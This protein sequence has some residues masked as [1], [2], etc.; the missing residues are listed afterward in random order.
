MATAVEREAEVVIVG[1]G[2]V[3]CAAAYYLARRGAKVVVVEKGEIAHEQ[4]SR[5]WGWIHQQ[6]RYP[7]LI[8]LA[9]MSA[10][11]WDG[12][13]E[14][15]GADLEWVRGGNLTLGFD[16]DQMAEFE[17]WR[18]PAREAGLETRMLTRDGVSE[19]L[20][21]MAGPW[22]G[23]IHVPSDGQASPQLAT[24]AFARAAQAHGATIHERCSVEAIELHDGAVSGVATERGSIRSG[25]VVVAAGAWSARLC[26]PLGIRLPQRAVRLTVVRTTPTEPVTDVTAWGDRV[27]FRQDRQ[28]RFILAGGG[29]ADYDLNL[30]ALR[31]LRQFV[32][33]AW[34]NRRFLRLRVGRPLLRDLQTLVP[35]T[36]AR[37]QPFAHLRDHEP[38][39]NGKSAQLSLELFKKLFPSLQQLEIERAW[40]GNIDTTPDQGPVLGE[41]GDLPGLTFAT[42]F[43]G[44]GFAMGPG[45]GR[46]VSELILDEGTSLDLH[47]Y[48]Y[49]R[50]AEHD[51]SPLPAL[52]L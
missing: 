16:D 1:A 19:L 50:F 21:T 33:N 47:K 30:D 48:R 44:H 22:I 46:I 15:L 37:R 42:G 9:A 27:T 6:T 10:R 2:I 17:Q 7:H 28:G 4:S 52:R 25:R 35:G 3:G 32:P 18:G 24:A 12:V 26:R 43:S 51:L 5:N 14:E 11:I 20:P 8:P 40:A 36:R 31:D 49:A 34:R 38:P 45:G 39:P 41:T 29:G 23:A 13:E